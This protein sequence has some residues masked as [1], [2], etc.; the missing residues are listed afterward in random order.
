MFENSLQSMLAKEF[1]SQQK[2]F[3][4]IW[5]TEM[6][7]NSIDKKNKRGW[8]SVRGFKMETSKF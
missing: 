3:S 8:F 6:Q 4:T 5:F 1:D 7:I 2:F